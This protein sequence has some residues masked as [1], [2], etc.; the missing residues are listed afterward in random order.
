MNEEQERIQRAQEH[1]NARRDLWKALTSRVLSFDEV[2]RAASFGTMLNIPMAV[3]DDGRST[4]SGSYNAQEKWLELNA[5]FQI[6][7]LLR[8]SYNPKEHSQSY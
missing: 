1:E 7:I 2:K 5:A 6:Q 3:S 4:Y 8:M